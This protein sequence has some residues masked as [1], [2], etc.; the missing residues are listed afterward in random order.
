M[1]LDRRNVMYKGLYA[2]LMLT[3]VRTF[4]AGF[5]RVVHPGAKITI[6][7]LSLKKQKKKHHLR[8]TLSAETRR[9]R[10][11]HPGVRPTLYSTPRAGCTVC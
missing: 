3:K 11:P 6:T 1:P 2:L 9:L 4:S 10:T 5:V 8:K 7:L